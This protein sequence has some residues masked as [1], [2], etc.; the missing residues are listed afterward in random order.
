MASFCVLLALLACAYLSFGQD[1]SCSTVKNAYRSKRLTE[2]EV[3]STAVDGK[4]HDCEDM[5]SML[6]DFSIP[7]KR[8]V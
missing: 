2:G 5:I 4:L 3:P 7:K 6:C 8:A 1:P